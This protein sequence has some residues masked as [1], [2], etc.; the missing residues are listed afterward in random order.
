MIYIGNLLSDL[1]SST[2]DLDSSVLDKTT[3]FVYCCRD[4]AE[5]V[6]LVTDNKETLRSLIGD[7]PKEIYDTGRYAIDLSSIG[8]DKVRIYLNSQSE[9]EYL[10][11]YYFSNNNSVLEKKRYKKTDP[12]GDDILIDRYD[13]NDN[14]I[15]ANELEVVAEKSDWSGS[16]SLAENIESIASKN[17]LRVQYS[18][19]ADKS[20]SYIIVRV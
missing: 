12:E 18:K 20:Q 7:L 1:H 19:K 13:S 3:S 2:K 4:G 17:N 15:S 16:S 10:V 6:T 8:T 11:G 5:S 9:N 14:L